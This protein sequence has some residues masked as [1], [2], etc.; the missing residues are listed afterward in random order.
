MMSASCHNKAHAATLNIDLDALF[1][2]W[3]IFNQKMAKGKAAAVVKANAYGLGA[4]S[5]ATYLQNKG[6]ADFFVA[7]L[8]EAIALR[9]QGIKGHIYTLNGLSFEKSIND[10][11]LKAYKEYQITPVINSLEELRIFHNFLKRHKI[12]YPAILHVDTGMR[13]LGFPEE[14]WIKLKA[15]HPLLSFIKISYIMSHLAC[16]DE[17]KNPYNLRQKKLFDKYTKIWS[18]SLLSLGNSAG[19]LLGEDYQGCLGRPG[20]GLYGGNPFTDGTP[21]PVESVVALLA[22][23]V[24]IRTLKAG[25]S[26]GYGCYWQAQKETQVATLSLGYADGIPRCISGKAYGMIEGY[27]LPIIGRISMDSINLDISMLPDIYKNIGQK[28]EILGKNISI[29]HMASWADT[30]AY[31]ILTGLGARYHRN[32]IEKER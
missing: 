23:I 5:I 11:L 24:Q 13:R 19:I 9:E 28:V 2:N 3:Q 16:G 10:A 8:S 21:S 17:P 12:R 32:Y 31:E 4:P 30:I 18:P 26:V 1:R 7:H 22:P 14:E 25:E 6:I 27:K 29:D 15:G 20:I